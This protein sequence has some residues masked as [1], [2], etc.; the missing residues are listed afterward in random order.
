MCDVDVA[1]A[2]VVEENALDVDID[3]MQLDLTLSPGS[4]L[5]ALNSVVP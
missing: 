3:V 5:K 4:V 2:V 1:G